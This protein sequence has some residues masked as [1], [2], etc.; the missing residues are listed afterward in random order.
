MT[1]HESD[2]IE[3]PLPGPRE[4]PTPGFSLHWALCPK[5]ERERERLTDRQR[6]PSCGHKGQWV[7]GGMGP[8]NEVGAVVY[9]KPALR[10]H[11]GYTHQFYMVVNDLR[12]E[13]PHGSA[14]EAAI[15][16]AQLKGLLPNAQY[17]EAILWSSALAHRGDVEAAW[18]Q[19]EIAVE[20]EPNR[21]A[22]WFNLGC[23]ALNKATFAEALEYFDRTL[24]GS[25][26]FPSAWLNRGIALS[27]LGRIH[28]A[29]V[30]LHSF[31]DRYPRHRMA[32]ELL[33]KLQDIK[34]AEP[35][36]L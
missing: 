28:E 2:T 13:V 30:S 33:R 23:L 10:C 22:G 3:H 36:P 5:S 16:S 24:E 19:A 14:A 35:Q 12:S 4:E 17:D 6:C 26:D 11:C 29:E 25:E 7:G 27:Q 31:L 34:Q 32:T 18:R 21:G 1:D 8:K 9:Y 15:A 20:I